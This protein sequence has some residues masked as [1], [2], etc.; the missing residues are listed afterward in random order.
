[1]TF[2]SRHKLYRSLK[3]RVVQ[4]S[5]GLLLVWITFDSSQHCIYIHSIGSLMNGAHPSLKTDLMKDNQGCY[6]PKTFKTPEIKQMAS[7]LSHQALPLSYDAH[8][9][10]FNSWR[11]HFSFSPFAV[12]EVYGQ[13][14]PRFIFI[15]WSLLVFGLGWALSID[16]PML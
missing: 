11:H 9:H 4:L 12:S 8:R 10:G 7:G 6:C 15:R 1:M 16:L 2:I 13:Y 14:W 5:I 3:Q